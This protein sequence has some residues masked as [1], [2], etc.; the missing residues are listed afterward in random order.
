MSWYTNAQYKPAAA[1]CE[2]PDGTYGIMIADIRTESY[3]GNNVLAVYLNIDCPQWNKI[4]YRHALFQGDNFDYGFSRLC[5]CFG[6]RLEDV[7][8]GRWQPFVGKTGRA[9]FSHQKAKKVVTGYDPSGRPIEEWKTERSQYA[10]ARLLPKAPQQETPAP[11]GRPM[12]GAE[13][14]G[15]SQAFGNPGEPGTPIY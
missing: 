10:N 15:M 5:D 14:A 1:V 12:S 3:Q 4:P 13:Q 8:G 11:Q 7:V 9:E 2:C 6:V